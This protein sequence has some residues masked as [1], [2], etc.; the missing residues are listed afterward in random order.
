MEGFNGSVRPLENSC[1]NEGS[2]LKS[3]RGLWV[4]R[5]T[6]AYLVNI[7]LPGARFGKS[8]KIITSSSR[9]PRG[10]SLRVKFCVFCKTNCE[11]R[12]ELISP[13]AQSDVVSI[14]SLMS[15]IRELNSYFAARPF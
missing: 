14:N 4:K 6:L 15:C 13:S 11:A 9:E 2:K 7:Q 1:I 5:L 12:I 10:M 3:G 8:T